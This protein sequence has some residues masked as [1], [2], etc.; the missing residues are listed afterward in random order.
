MKN[1]HSLEGKNGGMKD[2]T[3]DETVIYRRGEHKC[4]RMEDI[5]VHRANILEKV[6]SLRL[7]YDNIL[8]IVIE[9]NGSVLRSPG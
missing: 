9:S 7:F 2:D 1:I 8:N 3:V 5:R 6:I 4:I